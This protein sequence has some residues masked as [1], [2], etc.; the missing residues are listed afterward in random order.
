MNFTSIIKTHSNFHQLITWF[1][2]PKS[3]YLEKEEP[4]NISL[5]AQNICF[6]YKKFGSKYDL[7]FANGGYQNNK[8]CP[9]KGI[10]DEFKIQLIERLG[11][12][13]NLEACC[14]TNYRC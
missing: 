7:G 8:N 4:W 2:S 6:L 3:I 5:F 1:L 14:S 11:K 10:C 12:K 13:F 9:E